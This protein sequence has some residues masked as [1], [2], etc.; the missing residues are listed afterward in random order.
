M[1]ENPWIVN[2]FAVVAA[3][4]NFS[5]FHIKAEEDIPLPKRE[6]DG[7]KMRYSQLQE[8]YVN[9][10]QEFDTLWAEN[11]KLKGELQKSTFS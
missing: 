1:C 4:A 10:R 6:Y 5:L 9:L 2:L 3:F 8:D 11:V 7:L